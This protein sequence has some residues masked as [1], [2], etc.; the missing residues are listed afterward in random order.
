MKLGVIGGSGICDIDGVEGG[1]WISID[2][3]YGAPSDQIFTG[4]LNGLEVASCRG[5]AGATSTARAMSR[6]RPI[7]TP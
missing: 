6:I 2:T 5:T 7:S 3:P 4:T 1:S